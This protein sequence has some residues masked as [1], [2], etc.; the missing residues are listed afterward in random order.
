MA[1]PRHVLITGASSGLGAALAR[2][3]ALEH[4]ALSLFGRDAA[5]LEQAAMA[6]RPSAAEVMVYQCDLRDSG[7]AA[8]QL[9]AADLRLPVDL[10]IANAGIGGAQALVGEMGET[11]EQ[12]QTVV[13]TNLLGVINTVVPL[14]PRMAA[15]RSGHIA[16][17]GSIAGLLGLP[18]S[19]VYCA[20]KSAVHLYGEALR[21]LLR[22]A[23]VGVTVVCPGFVDTPMS[24][25]LPMA[26]P[27]LWTADRAAVRIAAAIDGRR[28]MF[29]FPWQLRLAA[30]AARLLPPQLVDR[31][32][33]SSRIGAVL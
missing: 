8:R 31:M 7:E 1:G 14:L 10:L 2:H 23:G 22:G 18:Q 6:C 27:F 30:T 17:M 32:L 19:P 5:R 11:I 24:A 3:Y 29:I 21:R 4:C 33:S 26:R 12:A 20:A 25:S 13:G 16:L 28:R 15:R 9:V